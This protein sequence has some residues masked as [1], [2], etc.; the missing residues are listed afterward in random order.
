VPYGKIAAAPKK[1]IKADYLP[2]KFAFRR[3]HMMTRGE[4]E[5]FFA[6]VCERQARHGVSQAFR[7]MNVQTQFKA[8]TLQPSRYRDECEHGQNGTTAKTGNTSRPKAKTKKQPLTDARERPFE[9]IVRF[10]NAGPSQQ[11][12]EMGLEPE[13][14]G[15][16]ADGP[17]PL[18]SSVNNATRIDIDTDGIQRV[19]V[20]AAMPPGTDSPGEDYV[21]VDYDEMMRIHTATQYV[22]IACNGPNDGSVPRYRI[23][24]HI[25]ESAARAEVPDTAVPRPVPRPRPRGPLPTPQLTPDVPDIQPGV[26]TRQRS[27]ANAAVTL[28]AA[29]GPS[30]PVTRLANRNAEAAKQVRGTAESVTREKARA[31]PKKPARARRTNK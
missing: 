18:P 29:P 26:S 23:P 21:D 31:T 30:R 4:I 20:G 22:A 6:F 16:E 7:F 19:P 12:A 27:R 8:A 13:A 17:G 9:H 14:T 2:K 15:A 24:N 25:H 28:S 10:D 5:Q 3:P 11:R 1:Y